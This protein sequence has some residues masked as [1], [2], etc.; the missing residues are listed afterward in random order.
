MLLTSSKTSDFN[1]V[2]DDIQFLIQCFREVLTETGDSTLAA[3]LPW[4]EQPPSLT[5]GPPSLTEGIDPLRLTQAYSIAFQ[6][7]NIVEENAVVQ[8]RRHLEK[9][10]AVN[11]I[12]GLW[13]AFLA[14]GARTS[15]CSSSTASLTSRSPKN[16]PTH[17]SNPC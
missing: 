1:K 15:P 14:C 8:Y 4:G 10:D 9:E 5:E 12:S 17:G 16:S 11:R 13:N 6:L 3:A 7:L 2:D